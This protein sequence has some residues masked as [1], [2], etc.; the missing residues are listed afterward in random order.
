[1]VEYHPSKVAVVGSSPIARSNLPSVFSCRQ[2]LLGPN[3]SEVEHF[4]GKEE[5]SGSIPDLGSS[6]ASRLRTERLHKWMAFRELCLET[7][8]EFR[9]FYYKLLLL[10]K[11]KSLNTEV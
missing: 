9:I 2:A 10:K 5:V 11:K 1:L 7:G 4:L 3:S 8:E 6:K